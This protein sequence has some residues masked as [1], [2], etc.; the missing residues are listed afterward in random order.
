MAAGISGACFLVVL[1]TS[2]KRPS[3]GKQRRDRKHAD[4]K[5]SPT[6]TGP[7]RKGSPRKHG[8][9]KKSAL[10]APETLDLLADLLQTQK[11]I[12]EECGRKKS[13]HALKKLKLVSKAE[14][15]LLTQLANGAEQIRHDSDALEIAKENI[16]NRTLGAEMERLVRVR[17]GPGGNTAAAV[18]DVLKE[19][20]GDRRLLMLAEATTLFARVERES[21][22]HGRQTDD[23]V[24]YEEALSK[25]IALINALEMITAACSEPVPSCKVAKARRVNDYFAHEM[26]IDHIVSAEYTHRHASLNI[27]EAKMREI[28]HLFRRAHTRN[29]VVRQ[30]LHSLHT[31][32]HSQQQPP[33][34]PELPAVAAVVPLN[35]K[36]NK[37]LV[38]QNSGTPAI[39]QPLMPDQLRL[40]YNQAKKGLVSYAEFASM[41]CGERRL[42]VGGSSARSVDSDDKELAAAMK[43]AAKAKKRSNKK[44]G[45]RA[46]FG[47]FGSGATG[48][49]QDIGNLIGLNDPDCAL[50]S[51]LNEEFFRRRAVFRTK[52]K[53]RMR[54]SMAEKNRVKHELDVPGYWTRPT[55]TEPYASLMNE[56]FNLLCLLPAGTAESFSCSPTDRMED[57]L[58]E[59]CARCEGVE[60]QSVPANGGPGFVLK[61]RGFCD[62]LDGNEVW[63][64]QLGATVLAY[65]CA[66][67]ADADGLSAC[68]PVS[69]ERAGRAGFG[70]AAEDRGH[71]A[72][73]GRIT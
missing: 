71:R 57:L 28:C 3:A 62:Y 61:A 36:L 23:S 14:E 39:L 7:L 50:Q 44:V 15:K 35:L 22:F 11:Q 46:V 59:I 55:M 9:A 69:A 29:F 38:V 25:L 47:A 34:A 72:A 45:D 26:D 2:R 52:M 60:P 42:N 67:G 73:G 16:H 58:E 51:I 31:R 20:S 40:I 53:A 64:L 24:A 49:S 70:A 8:L 66:C 12:V 18:E 68:P 19:K 65:G 56:P 13:G 43:K 21:L 41:V 32:M 17:G 5:T 27:S 37:P 6:C 1:D 30:S 54:R 48:A 4:R 10:L 63:Q 33:S